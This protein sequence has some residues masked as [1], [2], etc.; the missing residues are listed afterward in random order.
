[1]AEPDTLAALI[2]GAMEDLPPTLP[3]EAALEQELQRLHQQNPSGFR[4]VCLGILVQDSATLPESP[5]WPGLANVLTD[6]LP[7]SAWLGTLADKI[8]VVADGPETTD[9]EPLDALWL[10]LSHMLPAGKLRK[11]LMRDGAVL[12]KK[13]MGICGG[14]ELTNTVTKNGGDAQNELCQALRAATAASGLQAE[15]GQI[16]REIEKETR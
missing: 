3:P 5:V 2:K 16:P 11:L 1:M 10:Q 14:M 13:F 6:S 4:D 7:A 15:T 8:R 12:R 9:V